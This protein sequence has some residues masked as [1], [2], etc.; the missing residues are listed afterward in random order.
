MLEAEDQG[1]LTNGQPQV[2]SFYK[3]ASSGEISGVDDGRGEERLTQDYFLELHFYK[4]KDGYSV[5]P[6]SEEV[7][8][9]LR[10]KGSCSDVW[11]LND[12]L[13][14]IWLKNDKNNLYYLFYLNYIFSP[15]DKIRHRQL[16]EKD[17]KSDPELDQIYSRAI[18]KFE[19]FIGN[20]VEVLSA[21]EIL[22]NQSNVTKT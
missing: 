4:Q 17:R 5:A 2:P 20:P 11:Y 14:L 8:N 19:P 12:N 9:K 13:F 3:S 10:F 18:V 21:I 6:I 22:P 7:K 16:I 15:Q 1:V